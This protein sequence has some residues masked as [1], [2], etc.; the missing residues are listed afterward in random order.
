MDLEC[1]FFNSYIA[2]I[3]SRCESLKGMS[4]RSELIPCHYTNLTVVPV[5]DVR[6]GGHRKPLDPS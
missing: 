1:T 4:E 2:D 5:S 3:S 6:A